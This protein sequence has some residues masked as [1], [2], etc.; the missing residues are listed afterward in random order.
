MSEPNTLAAALVAFQKEA[1]ELHK[2]ST[3]DTGK[4]SYSYISLDAALN[5]IRP[6]LVKHGLTVLQFPTTIE[7]QPAL[8]TKLV[9]AGSGEYE[10]DTM[11]LLS[12]PDPQGQGSA[13]TYARRY[14]LMALLGLVADEDKDGAQPQ[15]RSET[16]EAMTTPQRNKIFALIKDLETLHATPWPP[17]ADWK[18]AVEARCHELFDKGIGDLLKS[19]ASTVIEAMTAHVKAAMD[20]PGNG[21]GFQT[22]N[23]PPLVPETDDIPF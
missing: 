22:P 14:S 16:G 5:Q 10:E 7:G 19:E 21:S 3:A 11:L 8:R 6:V 23:Q 9:H 13:I 18:A 1:P 20:E 15:K 12:G 2:D 17:H 4:F